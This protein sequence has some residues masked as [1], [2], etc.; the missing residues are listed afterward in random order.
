MRAARMYVGDE[1]ISGDDQLYR[2]VSVDDAAMTATAQLV[3]P[4]SVD[5][6]ALAAFYALADE[7]AAQDDGR[8]LICMYSTHSDESY[9][10]DDGTYSLWEGAGIYDVGNA[11][12]DELEARGI[13]TI[14]SE[15]SSSPM[16][17]TPTTVPAPRRRSCSSARPT[18]CWTSIATPSPRSSMR[19]PSTARTSASAPVRRSFQPE[20]RCQ[21]RL[22]PAHQAVADEEY[23]GLIKDIFIG[24]GNY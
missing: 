14:Y 1:Y 23:P 6:A 16:T 17:P 9:T 4:A 12:K 2:V 18:R 24:K 20:R 22:R 3:G 7:E 8:R 13:E 19:R 10:P 5:E 21:P 15:E 11:L